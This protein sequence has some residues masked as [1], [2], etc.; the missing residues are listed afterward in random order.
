MTRTNVHFETTFL[1]ADVN[2]NLQLEEQLQTCD[3]FTAPTAAASWLFFDCNRYNFTPG[4]VDLVRN[5]QHLVVGGVV[6][7]SQSGLLFY[8]TSLS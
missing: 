5:T 3:G 4:G 1:L 8:L 2:I 6:T 7:S